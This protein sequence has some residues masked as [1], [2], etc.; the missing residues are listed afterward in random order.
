MNVFISDF[1]DN[2]HFYR[3]IEAG[4]YSKIKSRKVPLRMEWGRDAI[5]SGKNPVRVGFL[6]DKRIQI[7]YLLSYYKTLTGLISGYLQ[8]ISKKFP[9]A[10]EHFLPVFQFYPKN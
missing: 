8:T 3:S 10:S 2:I 9:I 6:N 4:I 1:Q 5:V 7:I